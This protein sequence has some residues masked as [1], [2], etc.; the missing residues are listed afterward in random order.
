[1]TDPSLAVT[2]LGLVTA[3]GMG[4]D[5]T[6]EGVLRGRSAGARDERLAG[7]PVDI[8]CAVPGLQPARHVDRRSVLIH[9]RFVQLAIVAAREAVADA[10]LDPLTWDGARVGVVVGCGLGGVTTWETQHRRLLERGPE[11]VSALLVPMLVPNMAAGHLAMDLRALGPN[12]VTATA[13]ASGGTALGVAARLLRDG[14]C[15]IVVAGGTEAGVSP[16]MVTGFA[17]M[18]ALSRRVDD[19]AAASRPFDADRDGFVIGE[20]SGMLVLERAADAEARGATVRARLLGHG[21]SA[22]AHHV[23]APDPEGAGALRAMEAALAQAGVTGRDIDHVNAHGTSTPLNDAVE[24][25]VLGRLLGDRATVTSAKG[26][27]GH[28][29]GA[30]GAIEAALTVL[31][32]ERSTVPPTANLRRR[33]PAVDLDVVAD[34]PREQKVELAMSNSFGF[35]GQNAVLVFASP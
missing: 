15:D 16:L 6:W 1:M 27:L 26:V 21:A 10:G 33:D 32:I 20:G 23:T 3:A 34:A 9:D 14:T 35:G 4:V 13:C 25:A 19:P 29:L 12:L 8:A 30:A 24:A 5:A 28:T 2:G 11:A 31:S 17:Q 22:D 18:G 7:L